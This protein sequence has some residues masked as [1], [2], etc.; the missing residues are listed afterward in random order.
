[1]KKA[2]SKEELLFSDWVDDYERD[3]VQE[4]WD[5]WINGFYRKNY[6]KAIEESKEGKDRL[7]RLIFD[8]HS[9]LRYVG[10]PRNLHVLE[11]FYRFWLKAGYDKVA[12]ALL[13]RI[14]EAK[15]EEPK[16]EEP[17]IDIEP[18]DS[19]IEEAPE[20]QRSLVARV[21]QFAHVFAKMARG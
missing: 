21:L 20:T 2:L 13:V 3:I 8:T 12:K 15:Y 5:S 14:D 10:D 6:D 9:Y 11:G 7:Y 19:Y 18:E 16:Y 1:M 4:G 17:Q